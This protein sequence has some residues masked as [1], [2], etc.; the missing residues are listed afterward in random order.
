MR[1][2]IDLLSSN[3]QGRKKGDKTKHLFEEILPVECSGI[4]IEDMK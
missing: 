3:L 2:Q 4:D 1:F